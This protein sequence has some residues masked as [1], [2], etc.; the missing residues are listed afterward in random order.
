MNNKFKDKSQVLVNGIGEKD[1]KYYSNK[2]GTVI[3]RD[4][5]YLDYL[6]EFEDGTEDWFLESA[7]RKPY[8]ET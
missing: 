3:Q 5:Y 2:I 1:G 7:L 6:V 4:P 8:T